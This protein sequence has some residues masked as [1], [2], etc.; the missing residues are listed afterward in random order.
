VV[1]ASKLFYDIAKG[2]RA[3][4]LHPGGL[5]CNSLSEEAQEEWIKTV[6]T[7]SSETAEAGVDKPSGDVERND[8]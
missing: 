8:E 3:Y 1:E 2:E 4:V 7:I 6:Y 5:T